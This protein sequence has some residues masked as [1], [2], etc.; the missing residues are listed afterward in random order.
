VNF[1]PDECAIEIDRR[2]LPGETAAGVLAHYQ[3]I[4]DALKRTHGDLDAVMEPP[5]LVDEALETPADSDIA[6][7]ASDTLRSMGLDGTPGGVPFCS[8]ASKLSRAGIPTIIFGPGS[9]D[10]AHVADEYVEIDQVEQAAE[11][12]RRL[13]MNL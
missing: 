12:H 3:G 5:M 9:I 11:F 2:M 1:V 13:L 10:R 8:D 4:I 7:A 6:R